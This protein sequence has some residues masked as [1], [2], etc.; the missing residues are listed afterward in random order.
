MDVPTKNTKGGASHGRITMDE[1]SKS[2]RR[3]WSEA[4]EPPSGRERM[5][6]LR[7]PSRLIKPVLPEGV[8]S[9]MGQLAAAPY[10]L[11]PN[12][13]WLMGRGEHRVRVLYS[14]GS[15]LICN[16]TGVAR[17]V[18]RGESTW[19]SPTASSRPKR[20]MVQ[21]HRLRID[22]IESAPGMYCTPLL[23]VFRVWLVEIGHWERRSTSPFR[24]TP[25]EAASP[26]L[27]STGRAES[28]QPSCGSSR[29]PR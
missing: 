5:D 3:I 25:R 17:S 26:T 29:R 20:R 2:G 21:R 15:S 4:R 14:D 6:V 18:E 27:K 10:G 8:C 11:I 13:P 22:G 19:P 16:A 24:D 9:T 1:N 23:H 7:S 28:A 12:E